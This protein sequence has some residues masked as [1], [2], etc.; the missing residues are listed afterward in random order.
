M[1]EFITSLPFLVYAIETLTYQGTFFGTAATLL[2]VAT[3]AYL[4]VRVCWSIYDQHI[5]EHRTTKEPDALVPSNEELE[6]FFLGKGPTALILVPEDIVCPYKEGL[7]VFT[8]NDT[9]TITIPKGA[10]IERACFFTHRDMATVILHNS[11]NGKGVRSDLANGYVG[12]EGFRKALTGA[13]K[14]ANELKK[15][16]EVKEEYVPKLPALPIKRIVALWLVLTILHAVLP[17]RQT[18]IYV[19]GAYALQEVYK[20]DTAKELG[21]ATVDT[22]KA[23]LTTWGKEVPDL[24]SLIDAQ[25]PKDD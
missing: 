13:V 10:K 18:A 5:A 16:P 19:A 9:E 20:S 25:L 1:L 11:G 23:Q 6:Q 4:L 24:Q 17:T 7:S 15:L 3:L 21:N 8:I 2:L 14:A 22:I 12:L